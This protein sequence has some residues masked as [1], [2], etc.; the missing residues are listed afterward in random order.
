MEPSSNG[1]LVQKT[2][3]E[4][5]EVR[6][7]FNFTSPECQG[8]LHFNYQIGSDLPNHTIF[9]EGPSLNTLHKIVASFTHPTPATHLNF[10]ILHLLYSSLFSPQPLPNT[11]L[12]IIYLSHQN[13]SS[14]GLEVFIV[15]LPLC[16]QFLKQCQAPIFFVKRPLWCLLSCVSISPEPGVVRA[17]GGEDDVPTLRKLTGEWNSSETQI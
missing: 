11:Y 2:M 10:G 15:L 17:S 4:K 16:P 13:V 6:C 7:A 14:M 1:Y 12:F 3:S 8:S 9:S 5:M